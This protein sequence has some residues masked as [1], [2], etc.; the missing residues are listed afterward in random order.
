MRAVVAVGRVGR[1]AARVANARA[2]HAIELADQILDAPE[3]P[4]GKDRLLGIS[5]L[6]APS[7]HVALVVAQMEPTPSPRAGAD[8]PLLGVR[9]ARRTLKH[10]AARTRRP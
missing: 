10:G 7:D 3:A 6:S 9:C 1:V 8:Q 4:A 2:A 5:H